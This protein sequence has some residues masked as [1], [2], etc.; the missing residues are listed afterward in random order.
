MTFDFGIGDS[1]DIPDFRYYL[2]TNYPSGCP[3][4]VILDATEVINVDT[5]YSSDEDLQKLIDAYRCGLEKIS[6]L[7]ER[8]FDDDDNLY[9]PFNTPNGLMFLSCQYFLE[10]DDEAIMKVMKG[11]NGVF[12]AYNITQS[13]D[14]VFLHKN[15]GW[16]NCFQYRGKGDYSQLNGA[17]GTGTTMYVAGQFSA[18]FITEDG[19][20]CFIDE[21]IYQNYDDGSPDGGWESDK[22]ERGGN[23]NAED[24]V[25][26][27]Y[28]GDQA[29]VTLYG[30]DDVD[31]EL[32]LEMIKSWLDPKIVETNKK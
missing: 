19:E 8:Y 32:D 18:D 15:H 22:T 29:L 14:L 30:N 20:D 17:M 3:E 28:V 26:P 1:A 24:E 13:D 2:L 6:K 12:I 23:F 25:D 21:F 10:N 16:L 4:E 31:Y 7:L 9:A 5:I 11:A 27:C